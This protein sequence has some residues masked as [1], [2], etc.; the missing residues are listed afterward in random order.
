[1]V[2]QFLGVLCLSTLWTRLPSVEALLLVGY[3]ARSV[4]RV[5]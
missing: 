2:L 1:M 3:A 4:S 5:V